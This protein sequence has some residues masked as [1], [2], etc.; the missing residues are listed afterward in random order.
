MNWT[1]F[2]GHKNTNK[3]TCAWATTYRVW[4]NFSSFISDRRLGF[5]PV[6]PTHVVGTIKP[7]GLKSLFCLVGQTAEIL[8][9]SKKKR[10]FLWTKENSLWTTSVWSF[11]WGMCLTETWVIEGTYLHPSFFLERYL[12]RLNRRCKTVF[13]SPVVQSTI[14]TRNYLSVLV[15]RSYYPVCAPYLRER[16]WKHFR[17]YLPFTVEYGH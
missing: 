8:S 7:T 6:P 13:S 12:T 17:W 4:R 5:G 2:F 11:N 9:T 14:E 1:E 16:W 15:W 10:G 3:F